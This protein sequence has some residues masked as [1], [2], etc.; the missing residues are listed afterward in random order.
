M[1]SGFRFQVAGLP[2]EI[3]TKILT[4]SVISQGKGFNIELNTMRYENIN[5]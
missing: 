1:I 2:C 5:Y 3:K 4:Q